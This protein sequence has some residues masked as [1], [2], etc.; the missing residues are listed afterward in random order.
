MSLDKQ[1]LQQ[2]VSTQI[3]DSPLICCASQMYLSPLAG[4][5]GFRQY[6]RVNSTPPLLAVM[7]PKTDGTSESAG[8]FSDLSDFLRSQ[9]IP[10]PLVFACDQERN[11]LL[12]E[13]FGEFSLFDKIS[14]N[15]VESLY[16]DALQ[17]LLHL[18]QIPHSIF[19]WSV[20][21]GDLL[22]QE[23]ELLR[24]WFIGKLLGYSL[25]QQENQLLNRV[26]AFLSEQAISQPQVL[27]HRDYHSRNLM[28]REGQPSGVIDFQDAVWGPVTYDLASLLRDCYIRW[29]PKQVR[30]WVLKYRNM[31]C[32]RGIIAEVSEEQ[33]IQ[34]FDTIGLQRH[35]K[36]LGIFT[37][38]SLRDG[39]HGYLQDLP[40]V[41]RYSLEVAENYP[42]TQAFS[43][44][45][46]EV[47]LPRVEKL[48]WYTPYQL[49]GS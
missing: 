19:K 23:M 34:W 24:Q 39:K 37:R 32:A 25:S 27:V 2:W 48:P 13:N 9:D 28:Y 30:H 1:A 4:D 18:Q 11:Y 5:A 49:A 31:A 17:T 40:L 7:A 16:G 20:Y 46:K 22:L 3:E 6:F 43:Q 47:L 21:T 33:F 42:Q 10:A 41:I 14:V 15:N 26:F 12:I 29:T 38:L 44:W 35:L 8:Y 45:F 36:V